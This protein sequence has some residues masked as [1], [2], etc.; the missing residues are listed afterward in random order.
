MFKKII[1][2][3][4][5]KY[6]IMLCDCSDTLKQTVSHTLFSFFLFF[7]NLNFQLTVTCFPV[8]KEHCL[9]YNYSC[10]PFQRPTMLYMAELKGTKILL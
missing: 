10:S 4:G 3:I 1:I 9:L 5:K 8:F 2:Y 7:I 6:I